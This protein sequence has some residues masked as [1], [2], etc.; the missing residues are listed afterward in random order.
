MSPF[1]CL[2]PARKGFLSTINS[3]SLSTHTPKW[4]RISIKR[5]E[6]LKRRVII[7]KWI[8]ACTSSGTHISVSYESIGDNLHRIYTV[9]CAY[10]SVFSVQFGSC[11]ACKPFTTSQCAI[12]ATTNGH[13]QLNAKNDKCLFLYETHRFYR[14]LIEKWCSNI[15]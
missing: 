11:R 6:I 7:N 1:F 3:Y 2:P 5:N 13:K 4:R 8:D 10:F 15:M 9:M 14:M 12:C